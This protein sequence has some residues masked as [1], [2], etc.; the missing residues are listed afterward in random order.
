MELLLLLLL[1]LHL[2]SQLLQLLLMVFLQLRDLPLKIAHR[3]PG[4]IASRLAFAERSRPIARAGE[5]EGEG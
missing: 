5:T 1:L 4:H 2:L 3:V